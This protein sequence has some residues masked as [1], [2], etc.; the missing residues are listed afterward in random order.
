MHIRRARV[1]SWAAG[2]GQLVMRLVKL[3]KDFLEHVECA[4]EGC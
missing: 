3:V 1:E 2:L 4:A